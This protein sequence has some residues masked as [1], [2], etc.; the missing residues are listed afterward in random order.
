MHVST[1]F[2][3]NNF[4]THILKHFTALITTAVWFRISFL[5][6]EVN[7]VVYQNNMI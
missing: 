3:L 5:F 7:S 2:L 1:H 6:H 4:F